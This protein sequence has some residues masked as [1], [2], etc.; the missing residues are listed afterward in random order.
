M[1]HKY[2]V[3]VDEFSMNFSAGTLAKQANGEVWVTSG[4]TTILVM[5]TAAVTLRPNQ[6]FFHCPLTIVRN[7]P[8]QAVCLED[9]THGK[10]GHRTKKF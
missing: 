8:Q 4:E 1:N 7:S 9:T 2:E 6:D 10:G 5:A 3:G